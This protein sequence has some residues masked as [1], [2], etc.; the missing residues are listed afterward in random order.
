MSSIVKA[1][2]VTGAGTGI[3]KAVALALL[4]EGYSVALAGRRVELLEKAI[5]ESGAGASRSLAVSTDVGD[6]Q[7]VRAMFAKTKERLGRL[8]LL[9]NNAGMGAPPVPFHELPVEKWKDV[10]R[11]SGP[12]GV[13]LIKGFH[14]EA[15]A[16]K[17]RGFRSSRLGDQWR[18]MYRVD[19][20]RLTYYVESITAHDCRRR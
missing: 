1:A 11:L 3:G 6:P 17:S 16:G 5:A 18:V 9:F 14:D 8:D 15:L 4:K 13:R 7:S 2:I 12:R 20:K 10:V 19:S